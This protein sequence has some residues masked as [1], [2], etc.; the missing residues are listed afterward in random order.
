[1]TKLEN[2]SCDIMSTPHHRF[3]S[4]TAAF[5]ATAITHSQPLLACSRIHIPDYVLAPPDADCRFEIL[6]RDHKGNLIPSGEYREP[7][8]KTDG[9]NHRAPGFSGFTKTDVLNDC[10]HHIRYDTGGPE[11]STGIAFYN[12]GKQLHSYGVE[13]LVTDVEK[14]EYGAGLCMD[15][16]WYK[17]LSINEGLGTLT[18]ET[19]DNHRYIFSITTGQILKHQHSDNQPETKSDNQHNE[20]SNKWWQWWK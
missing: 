17:S 6:N 12:L 3:K 4:L 7:I 13:H 20:N 2:C 5:L 19:I 8:K 14:F 16:I 11:P 15:L 9:D 10:Q 1:M 18:L